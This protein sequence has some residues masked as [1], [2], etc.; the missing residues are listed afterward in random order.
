MRNT[1]SMCLAEI[2]YTTVS[3][4][5]LVVVK[6]LTELNTSQVLVLYWKRK[7]VLSCFQW[8]EAH[9]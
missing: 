3:H 9:Y 1:S 5:D 8:F 6:E 4:I 7:L 2:E